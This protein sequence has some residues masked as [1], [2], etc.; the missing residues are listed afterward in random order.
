MVHAAL[1]AIRFGLDASWKATLL[2]ALALCLAAAWR[3]LSAASR[4]LIVLLG[5]AGALALPLIAPLVP[6]ISIPLVPSLLPPATSTAAR[7]D[8]PIVSDYV[9]PRPADGMSTDVEPVSPQRDVAIQDDGATS[10]PD[11]VVSV[12]GPATPGAWAPW[13]LL[14]W[15]LGAIFSLARLAHGWI[16]IRAIAR[17]ASPVEDPEWIGST[18]E[19]SR[20][21]S[22]KRSVR[23]LA[24]TDVPVAMTAGLRRPVLLVHENARKWPADRRRVVLLHELAHVRRADWL[25]LLLVELAA[26]VYW[27]HPLVWLARREARMSAERACDDLVLDSGTKP[28]VYAAHLLGI[29][30]SFSPGVRGA[31]PVLAIARPSQFEGRMRAILATGLHR[32]GPSRGQIRAAALGLFSVVL[33]LASLEPWAP[34]AAAASASVESADDSDI[35]TGTPEAAVANQQNIPEAA[36]ETCPKSKSAPSLLAKPADL[37]RVSTGE[38]A[39]PK[40]APEN[41]P[42]PSFQRAPGA[43]APPP[44]GFVLASNGKGSGS[45]WYHEGMEAHGDGRYDE[46]IAAFQ[47]SIELGYKEGASSYNIACGYALK[48]DLDKAFE[49][50]KKAEQADFDISGYL[51]S[52]D[53]LDHLRADPRFAALRRESREAERKKEHDKS[54]VVRRRYERLAS[55]KGNGDGYFSVGRELLHAGE[56]ALAAEAFRKSAE[57]GNRSGTSLYNAGCA[58]SL[59]GEKAAAL[60]S[61]QKALENGFDDPGM[62]R[63]DDDLDN[64]RHE[65]R[66]HEIEKLADELAMPSVGWSQKLLRSTSRSEWGNAA[67]R[68]REIAA[69]HPQMGRVWYTLGYAEIRSER[70]AAAAEAFQ[71]ALDLG[72][73]KPATLYNLACSFAEL[74]QKDRAFDF[75]FRALDAGYDGSSMRHD[76]D[77]D[78]IRQD[79]RF[80]KAEKLAEK[81]SGKNEED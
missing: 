7:G 25:T 23:L 68:A 80:R 1:I 73:R 37:A 11:A 44:A 36:V 30:R 77:L 45:R 15:A 79:P 16:R 76:E 14:V 65:P 33:C 51:E 5:L 20:R 17:A 64:V 32:R 35:W 19:L 6:S 9:S 67:R 55:G 18:R 63:K 41:P 22:L 28:S 59:A 69:R 26:A 58:L 27:F 62:F 2:L 8:R 3:P 29:V 60:D 49:W 70:P 81:M 24:S 40:A 42:A 74:D 75:L 13:V 71:K 4:H 46:A 66:F 39:D 34:R 10:E 48:K 53:D 31:L 56:N 50:L 57:L 52:D 72:Y 12:K 61:L 78:R 54:D 47:K 43:P 21:I 38:I